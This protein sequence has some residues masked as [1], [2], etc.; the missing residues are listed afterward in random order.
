MHISRIQ[1]GIVI[2]MHLKRKEI[3][4][5]FLTWFTTNESVKC[6]INFTFNDNNEDNNQ[7]H[8]SQITQSQFAV[9]KAFL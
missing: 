2:Q 5:E 4:F 6:V 8:N 3:S 7:L 1:Q 9:H